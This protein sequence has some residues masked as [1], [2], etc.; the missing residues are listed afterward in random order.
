M[1]YFLWLIYCFWSLESFEVQEYVIRTISYKIINNNF[2]CTHIATLIQYLPITLFS[3]MY[4]N[5]TICV[6]LCLFLN[7]HWK[8]MR[9]VGNGF[10]GVDFIGKKLMALGL[11]FGLSSSRTSLSSLP[12]QL[13]IE[14]SSWKKPPYDLKTSSHFILIYPEKVVSLFLE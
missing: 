8:W 4:M 11:L 6:F 3:I 1:H 14:F 7:S 2:K 12:T 10:S 5:L 9:K 13:V